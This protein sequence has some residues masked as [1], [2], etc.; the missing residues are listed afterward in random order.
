MLKRFGLYITLFWSVA[1]HAQYL[2][3]RGDFSI[4]QQRG[5]RDLLISVTNINPGTDVILY[6]Y[7]GRSSQPTSDTS[8]L[9]TNIGDYWL[10]QYIQ[11][12]TGEKVDSIFVQILDPVIP[13]IELQACNNKSLQVVINDNA[14]DKYEINY[15]DGSI[16]QTPVNNFPPI[17]TYASNTPTTVTVTG[18][19][20]TANNRCG[21][22]TIN[23]TP[24]N[25]VALAT[26]N[27]IEVLD[28]QSLVIDYTLPANT[29]TTLEIS[30][31]NTG[32]YQ[33][34]KNINQGTVADTLKNLQ[35]SSNTY[36]FRI[37]SHDACSNFKGY[38]NELCS[39]FA[40]A[41]AVNDAINVLWK[42]IYPTN[43]SRTEIYRDSTL[44][45]NLTNQSQSYADSSVV[46]KTNYCY[47]IRVQHNNGTTSISNQVCAVAF[48]NENPSTISDI[49]ARVNNNTVNWLWEPPFN[50]LVQ[51]YSVFD[52]HGGFLDSTS[53]T[54][55]ATTFADINNSCIKIQLTNVCG[56]TSI[57]SDLNC[58]IIVSSKQNNDGSITLS[59]PE[60]TGWQNGVNSYAI[61][62]F[63][64]NMTLL[65]SL[66]VDNQLDY[67]DP[68][69]NNNN[70]VSYYKVWAIAQDT[71]L[72]ES[73]SN[74]LR[75][76]RPPI[77]AIPN[78]FTPDGDN[79][80]DVFVVTGKFIKSI[81][82]SIFNR[83]G[84]TIYEVNGNSWD[85]RSNGKKVPLGNYIYHVVI[86]DFAG[87]ELIRSGTVLI[88]KD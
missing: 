76:E 24:V 68:L 10:L 15:G 20:N 82:L 27:A 56:N 14:Y 72:I 58:P 38:S 18:L 9:Y 75:I 46:C 21:N 36:C 79:I 35:L 66:N 23:F 73:S 4:D 44:L 11:G 32:S 87:N 78:A 63:D 83:W 28:D 31:N 52:D 17:Y 33:L 16:I 43:Y 51:S 50:E 71:G 3:V 81:E 60:Y 40:N 34:F 45:N 74:L 8:Y 7:E 65:D 55:I 62:I 69:P 64:E 25:Q 47:T 6:Q 49:S 77:I 39:V 19:Y 5:C 86:K 88:L 84:S 42:S 37:A 41:Q 67:I 54:N 29:I 26:I 1:S 61:V 2:S 30:L 85:G 48:S 53:Q 80:N 57:L 12:P 70:Q 22:N 13:A 59:W